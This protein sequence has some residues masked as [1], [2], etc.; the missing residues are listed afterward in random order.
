MSELSMTVALRP[1]Y[2]EIRIEGDLDHDTASHLP[3]MVDR[4]VRT[5]GPGLIVVDLAGVTFINSA[6]VRALVRAQGSS[7]LVLRHPSP[8]VSRVLTAT[9]DARHFDIESGSAG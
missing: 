8:I 7:A 9:G 6:G 4:L 1:P 3:E 2:P 5:L